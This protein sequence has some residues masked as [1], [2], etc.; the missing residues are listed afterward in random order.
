MLLVNQLSKKSIFQTKVYVNYMLLMMFIFMAT[1][2]LLNPY[3]IDMERYLRVFH[4]F[5]DMNWFESLSKCT[6]GTWVF[7]ISMDSI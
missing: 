2:V 7:D 1:I 3:T 4:Q 6:L 5:S